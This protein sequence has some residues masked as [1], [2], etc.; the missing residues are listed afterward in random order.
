MPS[1]LDMLRGCSEGKIGILHFFVIL[2]LWKG[3]CC[4]TGSCIN[5]VFFISVLSL[6]QKIS[7]FSAFDSLKDC[8]AS[9]GTVE[10]P[11]LVCVISLS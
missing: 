9:C 6:K 3:Q 8:I 11:S 4:I 2:V 10:D 7:V 5:A 1:T